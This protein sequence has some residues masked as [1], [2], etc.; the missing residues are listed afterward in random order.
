MHIPVDYL[1]AGLLILISVAL[2]GTMAVIP[3]IVSKVL[4][5]GRPD[6]VKT[7]PYECGITPTGQARSR[8]SIKFYVIAMLF[9]LFDI[10]AIF[11]YPWATVHRWLGIFGL[12]EMGIFVSILVVGYIYIWKR[13]AFEW[14]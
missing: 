2:A 14:E 3:Q 12:I 4:R 7:Q 13:G 1:F 8:F 10:E 5:L 11:L 9:I 6:L